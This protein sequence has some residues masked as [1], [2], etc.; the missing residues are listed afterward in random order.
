MTRIPQF[1]QDSY[2]FAVY[3]NEPEGTEVGV[4]NAVDLDSEPVQS[5]RIFSGAQS[6]L[7]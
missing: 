3:E 6:W 1:S 2:S 7:C 5:V 4:V